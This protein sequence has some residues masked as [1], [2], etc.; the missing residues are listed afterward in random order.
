MI[1]IKTTNVN[2]DFLISAKIKGNKIIKAGINKVTHWDTIIFLCKVLQNP[3]QDIA[4]RV[5][6]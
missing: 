5:H 4:I 6:E 1:D 2:L 3:F